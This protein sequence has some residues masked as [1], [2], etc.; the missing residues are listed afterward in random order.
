ME[1]SR[2]ILASERLWKQVRDRFQAL[3]AGAYF[4]PALKRTFRTRVHKETGQFGPVRTNVFCYQVIIVPN[5]IFILDT[6]TQ[7]H[8]NLPL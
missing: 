7:R 8:Y 6:T 3:S 2:P 5:I 1:H 4:G